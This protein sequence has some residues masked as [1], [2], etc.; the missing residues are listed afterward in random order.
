MI[1]KRTRDDSVVEV[2]F[3]R[4]DITEEEMG[5]HPDQNRLLQSLGGKEA[6]TPREDSATMLAGDRLLL[7]TDGLWEY[8]KKEEIAV[9]GQT[10]SL[11]SEIKSAVQKSVARA[12]DSADNTSAAVVSF[13][14]TSRPLAAPP[15]A[16]KILVALLCL[17]NLVLLVV[18]LL[19][20][21]S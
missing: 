4:G 16:S 12:G 9:M 2:L 5:S 14:S 21:F 15:S 8:L 6:P 19:L 1:L 10:S 11:E 18:I 7:C 17:T 20:I 13:N 3:E